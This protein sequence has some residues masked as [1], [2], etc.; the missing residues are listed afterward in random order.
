[1]MVGL[2]ETQRYSEHLG[3]SV[4]YMLLSIIYN[5]NFELYDGPS[6]WNP[7]I[8]WTSWSVRGMCY[9]LSFPIWFVGSTSTDSLLSLLVCLNQN[10]KGICPAISNTIPRYTRN[11][12]LRV[13]PYIDGYTLYTNLF[14]PFQT[15][16]LICSTC[17]RK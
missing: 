5:M 15:C 12:K 14:L 8:F 6:S 11:F 1:M 10:G 2:L 4:V 3:Q 17:V 9:R 13:H 16:T 7:R